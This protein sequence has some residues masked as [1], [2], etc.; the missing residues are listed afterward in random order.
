MPAYIIAIQKDTLEIDLVGA[1]DNNSKVRLTDQTKLEQVDVKV[2]DGKP[3]LS[4]KAI[5]LTDLHSEQPI[6]VVVYSDGKE[7]TLLRAVAAG[8]SLSGKELME[9]VEKLGGKVTRLTWATEKV[10]YFVDLKGTK[11]SGADIAKLSLTSRVHDLDLSFTAVTDKAIAILAAHKNLRS[12]NLTGTKVSD[13][14]ME[15]LQQIPRLYTVIVAQTAVTD[16][17]VALFVKDN[18]SKLRIVVCNIGLG[19]KAQFQVHQQYIGDQLDQYTLMIGDTHFGMYFPGKTFEEPNLD[20]HRE[21]TSYYHRRGPVGQVL[22]K[23]EWFTPASLLD[24]PSDVRMPAALV[25]LAAP[26]GLGGTLPTGALV[27]L[28]SEPAL[29]VVRLNLGTHA[30]YGRPFQHIHFYNSTPALKTFSLPSADQPVL[31]GFIQDALKRGC[32]LKVI[33][34]DERPTLGKKGPRKFY[35]ALF[36]EST[37]N[38]LRDINTDLFTKEALA[39]MMESLTET[40]VLCFHTSHRYHDLVPP[41]VDAAKSLNLAWKFGQDAGKRIHPS[42]HFS[43]EWVVVARKAEYL[44]HLTDVK[45]DMQDIKWSVPASTSQHLWRDGQPHDLKPLARPAQK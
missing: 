38:D 11:T 28:W 43:S 29:G 18:K 32:L 36:V 7:K 33:D 35:S 13:A 19:D 12:L 3:I 14:A 17:G 16:K 9:Q 8:P 41:L 25:A 40:G 30:A 23:L 44:S 42:S 10:A 6:S 2:V 22:A 27:N 39:E 15:H 34:G 5:K 4:T 21:A 26:S 1:Q 45:T 20:R 24:Y 31:F 37:H